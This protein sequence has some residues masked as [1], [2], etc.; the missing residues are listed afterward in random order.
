MTPLA[1]ASP[2]R[3]RGG[4]WIGPVALAAALAAASVGAAQADA[5]PAALS[6]PALHSPKALNAATLA[7]TRAGARLVAVG[8][9]GT[10]LLSDDAGATWRQA[11]VPV[12]A[13]LTTVRFVDAK[14]GWAAGHLGVILSSDDGGESWTLQLDGLKAAQA[15]AAAATGQDE[16]AQKAARRIVEEGPDKPFFDLEFV[17]AQRGYAVGAYSLAFETRDGGKRWTPLALPNPKNLHLYGVRVAGGHAFIAGEQGL[18]L[19]SNDSGDGF[20]VLASP[21]KGS[22]FGLLATRSGALIAYGLRGNALRSADQGASWDKLETG[23]TVSMSAAALLDGDALALLSQSG[24]VLL[25]RDDGKSFKKLPRTAEPV[26]AAGLAQADG[27]LVL[28]SL[29]GTRR[30]PAP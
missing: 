14:K 21:Y 15:I 19:K 3:F 9:R 16:R 30:Q 12:Q 22:F 29:R 20:T 24:E 6:E 8:E 26:P 23:V 13:T 1:M 18:L 27:Q 4:R 7:V 10:V 28:A 25:S 11:K 5:P 2:R 17:D